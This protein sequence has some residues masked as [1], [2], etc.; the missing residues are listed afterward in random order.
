M[1]ARDAV[2]ETPSCSGCGWVSHPMTPGRASYARR[3]HRCSRQ[4]WRDAMAQRVADREAKVGP[5][6]ECAHPVARHQHG[7]HAAY[8]LDRCRCRPCKD[9]NRAYERQRAKDRAYGKQAY[10]DAAPARQHCLELK[11]SGLGPKRLA[12]VSGV[13][14]GAI[15]RLL[16][17]DDVRGTPASRRIRQSTADKLLAVEVTVDT[18]GARI[19]VPGLPT[20]LRLQELIA[21]GWSQS[22][23]AARLGRTPSNFGRILRGDVVG[24]E[25]ARLVRDLHAELSTTPPPEAEHR[26]KIAA[27]SARRY[28]RDRG[29]APPAR[30]RPLADPRLAHR[31]PAQREAARKPYEWVEQL[32]ATERAS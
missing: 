14:H 26:D 1:T 2:R 28:A 15:S 22:K 6:R 11:A 25:S 3:R 30:P 24:A 23:L 4:L 5:T 29:W 17:G 21:M 8:V 16:Y 27:S 19:P 9:A 31:L 18:L 32:V 12:V 10:V 7:T 20:R 13:P